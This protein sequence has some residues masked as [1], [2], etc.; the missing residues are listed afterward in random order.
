MRREGAIDDN[1]LFDG[2]VGTTPTVLLEQQYRSVRLETLL[3]Y[4]FHQKVSF[5]D[6]N[7]LS[8]RKR[9]CVR[10]RLLGGGLDYSG[11]AFK[12]IRLLHFQKVLSS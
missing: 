12:P 4:S 3:L 1:A 2:N 11:R 7:L 9:V 6:G 8:P 10:H 5:V